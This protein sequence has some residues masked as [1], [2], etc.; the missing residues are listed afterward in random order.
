MSEQADDRPDPIG[1][2]FLKSVGAELAAIARHLGWPLV[3]VISGVAFIWAVGQIVEL[4]A[5]FMWAVIP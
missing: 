3:G 5:D 2:A 1:R 4:L